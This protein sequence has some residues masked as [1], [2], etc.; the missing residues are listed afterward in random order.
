MLWTASGGTRTPVTDTQLAERSNFLTMRGGDVYR[1]AVVRMVASARSVLEQSGKSVDDIDLFVGHQANIRILDAVGQR[2]GMPAEKSHVTVDQ[3]A[4]TSAASIPLALV[5]A[6]AAG[7]LTP[8][9]TVLLAAF[10]AGLTWG[11]CLFTWNPTAGD[12]GGDR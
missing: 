5:D 9:A 3:H 12:R 2:L 10:G 6:R 4:N 1:N 11:A 7:R 8:G